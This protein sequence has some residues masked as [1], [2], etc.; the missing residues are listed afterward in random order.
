MQN[1]T[2]DYTNIEELLPFFANDTLEGTERKLVEAAL[3]GSEALRQQVEVLRHIRRQ[4]QAEEVTPLA[5]DL[6]LARLM[7]EVDTPT[8]PIFGLSW[9]SAGVMAASVAL[10]F[11]VGT[12]FKTSEPVYVQASGGDG[13][14]LTVRFQAN[15]TQQMMAETLLSHGVI[16]VDGPSVV[17]Y[18]RL[19]LFDEGDLYTTAEALRAQSAV[20]DYVD[21]PE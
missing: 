21:D 10:A 17:G 9:L 5:G 14:S 6:G 8:A 20:F 18:Y 13:A 12:N 15:V 2:S 19:E 1:D 16:I 11:V 4:M 3:E 7:R